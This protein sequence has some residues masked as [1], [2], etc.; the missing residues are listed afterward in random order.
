MDDE[1]KGWRVWEW[2]GSVMNVEM[3]LLDVG[4]GQSRGNQGNRAGMT[5]K[6]N[7]HPETL[8]HCILNS[9]INKLMLKSFEGDD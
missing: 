9:K 8:L 4:M 3:A 2:D 1:I 5:K 7:Y 6:R